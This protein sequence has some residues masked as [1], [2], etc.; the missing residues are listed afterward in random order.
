MLKPFNSY[1][2][3]IELSSVNGYYSLL[4][5]KPTINSY[6]NHQLNFINLKLLMFKKNSYC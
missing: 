6:I 2:L 3:L 1:L 5:L 4:T